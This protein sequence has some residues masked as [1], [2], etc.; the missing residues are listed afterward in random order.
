MRSNKPAFVM[1]WAVVRATCGG[2]LTLHVESGVYSYARQRKGHWGQWICWIFS[3]LRPTRLRFTEVLC[4]VALQVC[5]D[6]WLLPLGNSNK[7]TFDPVTTS[8]K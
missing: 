2:E 4:V 6:T 8:Q 5:P 3:N 1:A 7:K